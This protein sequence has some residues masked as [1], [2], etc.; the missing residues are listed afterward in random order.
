MLADHSSRIGARHTV[1]RRLLMTA[2]MLIGMTV[3]GMFGFRLVSGSPW[4][5]CLYMAVITLT[6]VGYEESVPLG[7]AGRVFVIVYLIAGFG[8]FTYAAVQRGQLAVSGELRS[9]F[10]ARG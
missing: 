7:D 2:G 5:D 3:V 9:L 6:T 10:E 8:S 1:L 4:L